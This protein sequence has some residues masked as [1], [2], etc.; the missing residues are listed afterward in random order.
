MP[1]DG[2]PSDVF[3]TRPGRYSRLG[4]GGGA[5]PMNAPLDTFAS[6]ALSLEDRPFAGPQSAKRLNLSPMTPVGVM[7]NT[8]GFWIEPLA[9]VTKGLHVPPVQ[10]AGWTGSRF[11]TIQGFTQSGRTG[12]TFGLGTFPFTL[13]AE[14]LKASA[15]AFADIVFPVFPQM[16]AKNVGMLARPTCTVTIGFTPKAAGKVEQSCTGV[17][18][19]AK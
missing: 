13:E 19:P 15:V 14:G 9:V 7:G 12:V 10:A 3:V 2:T 11:G 6:V 18:A 5:P 1:H 4:G 17:A 8:P 16:R